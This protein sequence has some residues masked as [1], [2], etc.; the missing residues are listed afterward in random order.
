MR[1]EM[2]VEIRGMPKAHFTVCRSHLA[3]SAAAV[4]PEAGRRYF[5][6]IGFLRNRIGKR[7][8]S[9]GMARPRAAREPCHS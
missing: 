9:A 5:V 8:N 2:T 3:R 4:G 6:A 7:G 1:L